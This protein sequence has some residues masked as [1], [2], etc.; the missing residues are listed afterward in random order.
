MKQTHSDLLSRVSKAF[1]E[2][3]EKLENDVDDPEEMNI[4][5]VAGVTDEP[6][7]D[8]RAEDINLNLNVNCG[9]CGQ[10]FDDIESL[11]S[12]IE[13]HNKSKVERQP[14]SARVSTFVAK[15]G[16]WKCNLCSL[17]LRTSRAL[18][19]HK[20]KRECPVLQES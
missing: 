2:T 11:E 12:H 20:S 19:A 4:E 16:G 18:K 6:D 8:P 14:S 17:V 15:E 10:T 13:L 1:D 3:L 9:V 7:K 5:E